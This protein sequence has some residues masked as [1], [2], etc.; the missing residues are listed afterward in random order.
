MRHLPLA[1]ALA[2]ACAAP[3]FA[4]DLIDATDPDRIAQAVR[5]FGYRAELDEDGDG[6]PLIRTTIEGL[7]TYIHFYGC[8]DGSD[9]RQILFSAGFDLP[10]GAKPDTVNAWNRDK[11]VGRAYLDD[12]RD[13]FIDHLVL[14]EGGVSPANLRA[15]FEAW[16]TAVAQ[17]RDHI[18]F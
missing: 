8:R 5:D 16:G 7:D 12:E 13:P 15:Q 14:L 4:A 10:R 11:L 6:D 3:A 2:C 18:G 17:F 9:C 1:A